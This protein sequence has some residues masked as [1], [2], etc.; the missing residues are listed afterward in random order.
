[1]SA[2]GSSL[3]PCSL[4]FDLPLVDLQDK[5]AIVRADLDFIT[6]KNDSIQDSFRLW[7]LVGTMISLNAHHAKN[8]FI[9]SGFGNPQGRVDPK[10]SLKGFVK[11]LS[12]ICHTEVTFVE[13][14][15]GP[16]VKEALSRAASNRNTGFGTFSSQRDK[17]GMHVFLLENLRFHPEEQGWGVDGK[18]ERFTCSEEDIQKFRDEI[19]SLGEVYLNDAFREFLH[20]STTGIGMTHAQRCAGSVTQ[21]EFSEIEVW[22]NEEKKLEGTRIAV[23]G[24]RTVDSVL[25]TLNAIRDH[26]NKILVVGPAAVTFLHAKT[27]GTMKCGKSPVEHDKLELVKEAIGAAGDK[28]G[29]PVDFVCSP[30]LEASEEVQ[31][32]ECSAGIPEAMFAVDIGPKTREQIR[33][34]MLMSGVCRIIFFGVAGYVEHECY[35]EGTRKICDAMIESRSNATVTSIVSDE[36]SRLTCEWQIVG[37]FNFMSTGSEVFEAI[38]HG[39]E[40]PV[41]KD[42]LNPK[43]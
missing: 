25:G 24:G 36:V 9:I 14:C 38:L 34:A 7:N 30:V 35:R 37:R 26:V 40:V 1:M 27:G 42:G 18:G 39:K 19:A 31:V 43:Q 3:C 5:T 4:V 32:C 23:I 11:P 20:P 15:I 22:T 29:L 12:Q 6:E 21:R 17:P 33:E 41:L 8:V 16:K 2:S 13:D 28:L 10:Y